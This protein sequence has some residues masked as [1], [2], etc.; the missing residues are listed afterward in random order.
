MTFTLFNMTLFLYLLSGFCYGLGIFSGKKALSNAGSILLSLGLILNT[1]VIVKRWQIAGRPPFSNTYE[2]LLLLS[3]C[4]GAVYFAIERIYKFRALGWLAGFS[5]AISLGYC[6]FLD[7]SIRPLVPA[8]QS[9]WLTIHVVVLFVSYASF[10]VSYVAALLY[11]FGRR[12]WEANLAL[13]SACLAGV[14]P[15]LILFLSQHKPWLGNWELSR[16]TGNFTGFLALTFLI[17]VLSAVIWVILYLVMKWIK[18]NQ[19]LPSPDLLDNLVYKSIAFGFPLL[20][21]GIIA[22]A[23]WANQAWGTY[24]SW[25]PKETWSLITLFIYAIYLHFRFM[26]GWKGAKSTWLSLIGFLAVVF[27]FIGVNY[28]LSGL[29]SY[30]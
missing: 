13:Y 24:W 21:F 29:H 30:A 10:T 1:L 11:F 20:A 25:D 8:L 2:S 23:V 12:G 6:S 18:I 4:I 9:N 5:T 19:H 17:L 22:G 27:T 3:W 28:I 26:R 7:S 16:F 14:G 15:G